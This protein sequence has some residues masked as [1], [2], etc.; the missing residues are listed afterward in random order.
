MYYKEQ[1]FQLTIHILYIMLFYGCCHN[2]VGC[3]AGYS[4]QNRYRELKWIFKHYKT[5]CLV[6]SLPNVITVTFENYQES[7]LQ[8]KNLLSLLSRADFCV[9]FIIII[10][11]T[12]I[13]AVTIWNFSKTC[14]V[15]SKWCTYKGKKRKIKI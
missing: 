7:I 13:L 1:C 11:E 14:T 4:C 6:P 2:V 5:T 9:W 12:V 10:I 3:Y 8:Q 15:S